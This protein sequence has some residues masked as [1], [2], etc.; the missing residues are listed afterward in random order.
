MYVCMHVCM[1]VCRNMYVR[2]NVCMS[3]CMHVLTESVA[4]TSPICRISGALT[5]RCF[6]RKCHKLVELCPDWC[7]VKQNKKVDIVAHMHTHTYIYICIH[8]LFI[9]FNIMYYSILYHEKHQF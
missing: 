8:I 3:V 5:P 4:M 9:L 2:K 6:D 1:H 7:R